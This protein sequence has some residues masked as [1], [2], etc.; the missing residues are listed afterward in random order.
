MLRAIKNTERPQSLRQRSGTLRIKAPPIA[1]V[2][3]TCAIYG[4][5]P[6]IVMLSVGEASLHG[7]LLGVGFLTFVR[8]GRTVPGQFLL[9]RRRGLPHQCGQHRDKNHS[10]SGGAILFNIFTGISYTACSSLFTN[11]KAQATILSS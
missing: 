11:T 4:L 9:A 10:I 3:L 2:F 7:A 1:Q 5:I 8:N 6:I